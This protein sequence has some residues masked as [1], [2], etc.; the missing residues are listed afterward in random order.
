M[1]AHVEA[2]GCTL[3]VGESSEIEDLLAQNGWELVDD[4][5]GCDL[6]VLVTCVVIQKT[7]RKMLKRVVALASAPKFV[8]TGC[9]ATSC[10]REAELLAPHASFIAPGDL[11]S[12]SRVIG[13]YS[14]HQRAASKRNGYCIVP[15]ATGCLGECSYCITRV[16]RGSLRSRPVEDV[17]SHVRRFVQSGPV[18]VR[19]TAQDTACYGADIGSNLPSLVRGVCDLPFDFRLRVGMM[20]PVSVLPLR[21]EIA[22][23]YGNRKVF[24]FLHLPIQSASDRVLEWMSRGYRLDD[25]REIVAGVR[26]VAH[27]ATLSTDLIVGYPG[28]TGEDQVANLEF[29]SEFRPDI[30]NV[31][32]FSPRPGT[33]AA[34]SGA[35]VPGEIVKARSREIAKLRF[36]V[37]LELNMGWVGREVTALATERGKRETTLLRTDEYRQIV[38][39][40]ELPL[41]GYHHVRVTGATRTFLTGERIDRK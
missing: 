10:R 34:Q 2:Y 22:E 16:A 1:K 32:R 19:M 15:I 35:I 26:A 18:E 20:N 14:T 29:I 38:V 11:Q 12:F 39:K 9:M 13:R 27:E 25:F 30:V 41:G 36:E 8:I 40:E 24:K 28:E 33:R 37:S 31:T 3:N 21:R 7:E 23:L 4:P 5:A 6:S 17:T